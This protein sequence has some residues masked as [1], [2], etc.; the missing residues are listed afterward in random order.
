MYKQYVAVTAVV[1][2]NFLVPGFG[3]V[4]SGCTRLWPL[5]KEKRGRIVLLFILLFTFHLVCESNFSTLRTP[6]GREI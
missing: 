1:Q 4:P 3:R 2:A 5:L 6:R